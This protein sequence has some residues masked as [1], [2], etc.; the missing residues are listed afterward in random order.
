M[1]L[2]TTS[3]HLSF[4]IDKNPENAKFIINHNNLARCPELVMQVNVKSSI[5]LTNVEKK[6][7][8]DMV[9]L[10]ACVKG[11]QFLALGGHAHGR[12]PCQV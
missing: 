3:G 4:F 1:H 7:L 8:S 2:A 5:Y 12:P 10:W 11:P 9:H 6:T